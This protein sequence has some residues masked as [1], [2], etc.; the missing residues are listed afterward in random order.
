[1]LRAEPMTKTQPENRFDL[2]TDEEQ[3]T[4]FERN[5][6]AGIH[7]MAMTIRALPVADD[8]DDTDVRTAIACACLRVAAMQIASLSWVDVSPFVM[9]LKG[10]F[11]AMR[12]MGC[13]DRVEAR[14]RA[15]W[16][17]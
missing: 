16:Q 3:L 2:S 14:P 5:A 11:A 9:F 10:Q 1:V 7:E 17:S 4:K 8:L 13:N 15:K 6:C 12:R